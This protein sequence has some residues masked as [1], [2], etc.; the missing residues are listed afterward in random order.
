LILF[1]FQEL[2]FRRLQRG[3][4][5]ANL[6]RLTACSARTLPSRAAASASDRPRAALASADR[7]AASAARP[8]L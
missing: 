8:A 1:Q 2:S 5:R 6:H 7:A 3:F 4:D